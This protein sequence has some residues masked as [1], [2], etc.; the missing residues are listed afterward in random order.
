MLDS[1]RMKRVRESSQYPTMWRTFLSA[2]RGLGLLTIA[3]IAAL[4]VDRDGDR[5]GALTYAV[6]FLGS[7]ATA[8][9]ATCIWILENVISVL[10]VPRQASSSTTGPGA[11]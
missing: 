7:L 1:P 2:T 11:G 3:A 5:T 6:L 10:T 9:V 8:Q 4:I